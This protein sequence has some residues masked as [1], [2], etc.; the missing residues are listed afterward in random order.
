MS[1]GPPTRRVAL[2]FGR[3]VHPVYR[4]QLHAVPPGWEY[5]WTHPALDDASVATKKVVEASSL[6]GP[7]RE[8]A[9]SAALRVLPALGYVHRIRP[10]APPGTALIHAAERLLW[11][12]PVPYV[13][14]LEH[15]E[16]FVLYQRAAFER[17]W[18]R[19]VLEAALLDE[20]LRFLLPWS[21]AAKRSVLEVVSPAA[22]AR[23]EPKLRVVLPAVRAATDR[24]RERAATGPLRV[25]FIGTKFYEKGGV[26]AVQALQAA[27]ATHDVELDLVSYVPPEWERQLAEEP[28]LRVH[29][30]GGGDVVRRLYAT[31][32]ALLF[33][34]H[35]DTYGVVVGEA[36]SYGLPVLAPR[37]LA[38]TET[39]HDGETGLLFPAENMLYGDDTRCVFRHTLPPPRSYFEALRHPGASY[40]AGIADAITR[41]AEDRALHA[42]LATGALA[43]VISGHL[44]IERRRD[45]L[46][47]I[48]DAAIA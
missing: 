11:R 23:L 1:A 20:R 4:E 46:S 28:G 6:L 39:I 48:Y 13:L 15:V 29:Q 26:E 27:R 44:S 3:H 5:T 34:S 12:S 32:D 42:R 8:R 19:P 31:C 37:H 41:L 7:A 22:A 43:S 35:M 33:P 38:L 10:Q 16:L 18:T 9:E 17:P 36:M 21:E 2:R 45:L 47:A 30:P 40:V 24:P 25:L 14:D